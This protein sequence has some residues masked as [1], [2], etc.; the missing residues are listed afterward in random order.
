MNRYM[1]GFAKQGLIKYISHLDLQR[2]FKR[3]FRRADIPLSYSQGYNPHPHISFAQPLSLGYSSLEEI[4]EFRTSEPIDT[5]EALRAISRDMPQGLDCIFLDRLDIEPKSLASIV[6]AADY[7]ISFIPEEGADITLL[8]EKSKDFMDLPFIPVYKNKKR[9]RGGKQAQVRIDIRNKIRDLQVEEDREGIIHLKVELD[10]GS[11]SNLS[12]E[13][14]IE[15]WKNFTGLNR[16]REEI[17]VR[18]NFLVFQA[19]I[20]H[21]LGLHLDMRMRDRETP[22]ISSN[23]FTDG[24]EGLLNS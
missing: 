9:R 23:R 17:E 19:C 16:N 2:L 10:A 24:S 21:S 8:K 11:H 18:R 12:P 13:L 3:A 15:S 14:L 20:P 7:D 1:L 5:I 4:V 6:T 22:C